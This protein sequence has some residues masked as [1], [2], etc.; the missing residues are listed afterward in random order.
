M[1]SVAAWAPAWSSS[2][3]WR[4]TLHVSFGA[5]GRTHAL[6]QEQALASGGFRPVQLFGAC[7]LAARNA[8][9]ASGMKRS[10]ARPL[11]LAVSPESMEGF[12]RTVLGAS[13][14]EFPRRVLSSGQR[15]QAAGMAAA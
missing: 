11:S 5:N 3:A 15:S 14:L 8:L 6:G 12:R 9:R 1:R 4:L 2:S 13:G 7:P 10:R